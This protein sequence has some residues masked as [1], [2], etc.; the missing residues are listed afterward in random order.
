MKKKRMDSTNLWASR[1]REASANVA[2]LI[3]TTGEWS[4]TAGVVSG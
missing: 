2:A 4:P 3:K 1:E